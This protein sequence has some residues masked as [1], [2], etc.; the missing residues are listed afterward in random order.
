MKISVFGSG[1]VG[2][3]TA[4]CFAEMDHQI[5]CCDIDAKKIQDLNNHKISI[6]EPRLSRLVQKN[7]DSKHLS[8]SSNQKD[9]AQFSS[10]IFVCVGTPENK[11]GSANLSYVYEL[12]DYILS[13]LKYKD[14]ILVIKSTVPPGTVKALQTYIDSKIKKGFTVHVASNPEFLREGSA[15]NDFQKPDRII[16]GIDSKSH[17]KKFFLLYKH[18]KN[19]IIFMD[20]ISSEFTKYAANAMLATKLSLMNEISNIVERV[21][22]DIE[23]IKHGIGSDKRIGKAFISP[24]PGYGGSCFPKDVQ[25]LIHT[26]KSYDYKAQMLLTTDKVNDLQ[27]MVMF[28]KLKKHF[29][30]KFANKKIAI[31]G[32]AFKA[33]TDDVRESPAIDLVKKL[34]KVNAQVAIYDPKASSRFQEVIGHSDNLTYCADRGSCLLDAD[35]LV[36]MTEWDEFEQHDFRDTRVM[37]QNIIFD[38][39]N[40]HDKESLN[41][42]GY[43]YLSMGREQ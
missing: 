8:F 20:P 31:W 38:A 37:K 36:I 19:K 28:S 24:G 7:L 42:I 11:D 22:G 40:L 4:A 21:G 23:A 25:A 6:Y 2:L 3:V 34:L 15:V 32:V 43:K 41:A 35:A 10:M 13:N 1:Y 18:L 5:L 17:K 39:R 29:S 14:T 27:K 30:D 12:I 16:V 26:A 33:N 9:A